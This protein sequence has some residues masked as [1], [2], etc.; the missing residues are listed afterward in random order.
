MKAVLAIATLATR[1]AVRSRVVLCL[2]AL[3]ALTV[4]GL[5]LTVKGDGTIEGYVQVLLSYT[6]GFSTLLLAV[7]TL[8][9]GCAAVSA[10]IA[11]RQLQLVA[12]KPVSRPAIWLG[13]WLGL[14]AVNTLLLAAVGLTTFGLLQWNTRPGQLKPGEAEKLHQQVLVARRRIMPQPVQVEQE[15]RAL[16]QERMERNQLAPGTNPEDALNAL[17]KN[18]QIRAFSVAPAGSV[19]WTFDLPAQTRGAGDLALEYKFASSLVEAVRVEGQ[20][21]LEAVTGETRWSSNLTA[22]ANAAQSVRLPAGLLD[23][24]Q[25]AR[26]TFVNRDPRALT[27]IF[28]VDHAPRLLVPAGGFAGNF[29]RALLLLWVRLAFLSAIGLTAGSLFSMPVATFFALYAVVLLQAGGYVESLSQQRILVPWRD[30]AAAPTPGL[31]DDLLRGF[32]QFLS[33]LLQPLRDPDPLSRLAAGE[34][35]DWLWVGRVFLMKV[36]VYSGALALVAGAVLN[37]RELALPTDT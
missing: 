20:W 29:V 14:L 21:R 32:Y 9:A 35:I 23:G 7:S 11:G 31:L 18:L 5:P 16:L 10:E 33:V 8:W 6:L 26:L 24:E 30:V 13:K 28:D 34:L 17:R 22:V 36:I 19:G 1:A 3:L 4:I 2:L 12:V 25:Q 15:A 37:R 27:L